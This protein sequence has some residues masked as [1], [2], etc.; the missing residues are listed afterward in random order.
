M[1]RLKA[2]PLVY[3][4]TPYTKYR[5]GIEA[6]FCDACLIASRLL[7]AGVKVYSPIAHTHPIATWGGLDP[8]DHSIWLPF[9]EAIMGKSD[10]ICVAMLDGWRESY[11]V[12]HEIDVFTK[13]GK[14]VFYLNVDTMKVSD[15]ELGA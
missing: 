4:A 12:K 5:S 6:A 15:L 11:G 9:D 13:A 2:F 8:L 1:T 7:L 14:P 3:L 10:A